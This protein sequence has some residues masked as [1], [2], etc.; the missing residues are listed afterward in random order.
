MSATVSARNSSGL[1]V[2]THT[3]SAEVAERV[4]RALSA[5]DITSTGKANRNSALNTPVSGRAVRSESRGLQR[6]DL[7]RSEL[8]LI[9]C[10]LLVLQ[11][12]DLLLN[13]DLYRSSA[14]DNKLQCK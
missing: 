4:D 14:F 6:E 12:F 10:L 3:K 2:E 7:I 8:L 11:R 1:T 9:K 13:G 5:E